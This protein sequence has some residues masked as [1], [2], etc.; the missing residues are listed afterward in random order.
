[1]LRL[2][3]RRVLPLL[4]LLV[5]HL[6]PVVLGRQQILVLREGSRRTRGRGSGEAGFADGMDYG[7]LYGRGYGMLS[8]SVAGTVYVR[9]TAIA[10]SRSVAWRLIKETKSEIG[11]RFV[12][13][14]RRAMLRFLNTG[15]YH[16][17]RYL[18]RKMR[19]SICTYGMDCLG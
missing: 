13:D 3:M 5:L 1:M 15:N 10:A 14:G 8:G 4:V 6:L 19:A 12:P 11:S 17:W 18:G 7:F 9:S 16:R 2:G